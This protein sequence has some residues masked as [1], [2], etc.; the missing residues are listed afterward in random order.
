MGLENLNTNYIEK[1]Q[2]ISYINTYMT[3]LQQQEKRRK[4][5]N[6]Y[7]KRFNQLM[8]LAKEDSSIFESQE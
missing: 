1:S 2:N 7:I 4:E 6:H 5:Y 3:S 8:T